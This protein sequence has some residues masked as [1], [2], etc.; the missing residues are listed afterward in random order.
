MI[1][2]RAE[3]FNQALQAVLSGGETDGEFVTELELC[4]VLRDL[5]RLERKS[6]IVA[7]TTVTPVILVDRPEEFRAFL[8]A[9]FGANVTGRDVG[10]GSAFLQVR[11]GSMN[12][13][14][15][16]F[17]EDVDAAYAQSLAAGATVLMGAVGEPADRPYGER[18]AFVQDPF[19][20][21]WFL[22]KRLDGSQPAGQLMPHLNPSSGRRMIAFLEAAFGATTLGVYEHEGKVM[23]AAVQVGDSVVEMGESGRMPM[24]L[25]L[26]VDDFE[27]TRARALAAGATAGPENAIVDPEGNRWYLAA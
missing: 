2:Q 18:S 21:Q 16:Y 5:P 13:S 23:H 4:G 27:A 20:N 26:V 9:A 24:A 22:G 10:I 19:G 17:V 12:A 3:R 8:K 15:H 1:E 7:A 11:Q 25:S 6:M 14:L